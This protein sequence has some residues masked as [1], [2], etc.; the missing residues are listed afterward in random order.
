MHSTIEPYQELEQK[1]AQFVGASYGV[2]CNSGTSALHLALLGLGIVAGDEVIVPDFTMGA[3]A[4]AVSYCGARP[5]FAD[6]SLDD[7]G[8]DPHDFERK[9]TPKTR[10]VI[11]AHTYGRLAPIAEII[12]IAREH[13]IAVIEDACEAQGAVYASKADATCWSFYKNKIIAAEEGG[14]VTTNNPELAK[15]IADL[16]NMAF[17]P[18]HDYFHE[19]IGYNYRMPNAMAKLALVSLHTYPA[20]AKKRRLIEGWYE[21]CIPDHLPGREAV[22]FYETPGNRSVV[23]RCVEARLPFKP[24]SSFPMYGGGQGR[25]N[26]RALSRMLVLLPVVPG[27]TFQDVKKI[28]GSL[29]GT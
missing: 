4:F 25:P 15:N 3:V 14:M 6:V 24:L 9:I 5:V 16:K 17:G 13:G 18:K 12:A 1:Y 27:M 21:K 11:L 26:A 8:M 10:A 19:R 7:Y 20:N 23:E 22:W 29:T 2:S 28:C